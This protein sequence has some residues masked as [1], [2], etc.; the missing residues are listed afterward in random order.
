MPYDPRMLQMARLRLDKKAVDDGAL[1][2]GENTEVHAQADQRE[3]IHRL[4]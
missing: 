4:A 1:R 2:V 3:E